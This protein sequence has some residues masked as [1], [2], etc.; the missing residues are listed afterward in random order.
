VQLFEEDPE[1]PL[2]YLINDIIGH[3]PFRIPPR[4]TQVYLTTMLKDTDYNGEDEKT[5]LAV[6]CQC[7]TPQP[8]HR[9]NATE[10]LQQLRD[11]DM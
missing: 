6:I 10:I 11:W 2:I 9:P 1:L 3:L 8:S 4:K 7:L 5:L